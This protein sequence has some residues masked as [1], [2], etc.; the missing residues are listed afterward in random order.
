M[1]Q[2][3]LNLAVK[4]KVDPSTLNKALGYV[5]FRYNQILN[6]DQQNFSELQLAKKQK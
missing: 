5:V 1:E 6:I 4:K 2:F 3:F